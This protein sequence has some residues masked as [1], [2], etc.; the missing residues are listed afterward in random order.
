M[1]DRKLKIKPSKFIKDFKKKC[2]EELI[3]ALKDY[4]NKNPNIPTP[5]NITE[6]AKTQ[7]KKFHS[8]CWNDGNDKNDDQYGFCMKNNVQNFIK[9]FFVSNAPN[10]N[11]DSIEMSLQMSNSLEEL[12]TFKET[13]QF[14]GRDDLNLLNQLI[15]FIEKLPK[16]PQSFEGNINA[17]QTISLYYTKLFL[18]IHNTISK[19]PKNPPRSTISPSMSNSSISPSPE[20]RNQV[21][22][23]PIQH[24]PPIQPPPTQLPH[25]PP[26]SIIPHQSPNLSQNIPNVHPKNNNNEN[27]DPIKSI[28]NLFSQ[29]R[30]ECAVFY[31][32]PH[33]P[34]F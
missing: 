30:T 19:T 13:T 2:E 10:Q 11:I 17:S 8:N 9:D 24:H 7:I 12:K 32:T 34:H 6:I 4:Y 31:A 3:T 23:Q 22:P 33:P 29:V 18:P 28:Q 5:P 20:I 15:S 21:P 27:F 26:P 14:I 1:E 25:T 16:N